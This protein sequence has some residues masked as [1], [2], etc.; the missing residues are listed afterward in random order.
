MKFSMY[1][2][3]EDYDEVNE[4]VIKA[5]VKKLAAH[6]IDFL[7][8]EPP[9]PKDFNA[10]IQSAYEDNGLALETRFIYDNENYKHYR[11]EGLS[12]ETVEKVF[13]NYINGI[14]PDMNADGWEILEI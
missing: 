7:V 10:Y 2:D 5:E 3:L 11:M 6:D 1:N 14:N 9:Q 8:L 12:K 13:L 4:A